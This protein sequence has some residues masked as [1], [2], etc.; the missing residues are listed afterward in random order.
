MILLTWLQIKQNLVFFEN[1]SI[2][3]LKAAY[4]S[5]VIASASSKITSLKLNSFEFYIGGQ[6]SENYLIL[7]LTISIPLSSEA[8]SSRTMYLKALP[9]NSLAQAKIVE[10]LPVPGEPYINTLG[11][12]F[13]LIYCIRVLTIGWCESNYER[14][15]GLYFSTQGI[16]SFTCSICIINLILRIQVNN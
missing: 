3:L 10:V 12:L 5:F 16:L 8:L 1:F 4:A 13:C 6:L 9:Y 2:I 14:F 7:F 11:K 15:L